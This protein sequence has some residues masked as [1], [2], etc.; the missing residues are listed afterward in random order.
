MES[1]PYID[2][3]LKELRDG[4]AESLAPLGRHIH[5]GYWQD[6]ARADGTVEDAAAATERLSVLVCESAAAGDGQD[7]LDVGC[8]IGGTIASL[9]ERL[10]G[11]RLYGLN[12]DARQLGVAR[13]TVS[14]RAGN[15][16]QFVVG[17]ACCLP[18]ENHSLDVVTAVECSFHFPSRQAF[19]SEA[20]RVLK[21]G[22]L[23]AVSDLV[24]NDH[25]SV[26]GPARRLVFPGCLRS[27]FYGRLDLSYSLDDY[28]RAARVAGLAPGRELD[29]TDQTMPTY[30]V[31]LAVMKER[32]WWKA[33][34][35][36][37]MLKWF[38]LL[39]GVRYVVLSFRA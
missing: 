29:I 13:R 6:P 24:T 19:L 20:K 27:A 22:G 32:R 18:F 33:Y 2:L 23:L 11:V 21:P 7:I 3:L 16:V 8:G 37:R 30:P 34:A 15:R 28:R 31:A 35:E 26:L 14:A 17:N 36:T 39:R 1:L 12:I 38:N 9:N 10:A 4:T 25:S 5:L